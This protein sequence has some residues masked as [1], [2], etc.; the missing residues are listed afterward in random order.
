MDKLT[1]DLH[2]EF[3]E[4]RGFST[5]HLKYMR[6]L[7]ETYA[8][9]AFVQQ[10]VA[11]M[12][13]GHNVI[14]MDKVKNTEEREWYI[15]ATIENGWS[16]N[17]LVHQIESGLFQRQGKAVTN[18]TQTLPP[19][20]S[21]LAQQLLK[22]PYTFDFLT[23]GD[24]VQERDVERG[25]LEQIRRTLLELG[26]GFAFVGSQYH[27][28]VGGQDFYLDLLFYHLRLRCFVVVDLKIGDFKP[29][30]AGK[31]NFYLAVADDKLKHAHLD[32]PSIGLILCKT[33]NRIIAEYTLRDVSRLIG[34]AEYQVGPLP[35]NLQN[36]LPSL[37]SLE[38]A[39]QNASEKAERKTA[40][41]RKIA[42]RRVRRKPSHQTLMLLTIK[43]PTS[44]TRLR[45]SAPP[46]VTA[47]CAEFSRCRIVVPGRGTRL[48]AP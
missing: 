43:R 44:S 36:S 24:E 14:L 6:L 23:L 39:L 35:E 1:A 45:G 20:Q 31:M 21:E 3:P 15:Q 8:D 11:Q 13:W 29:E 5:R 34:V 19:A 30:Y 28:E 37:Q 38:R 33:N 12:P 25:L 32:Q 4:M 48:S 22:D 27:L 42:P 10:A 2:H 16:R 7:A 41:G 40:T 26:A 46:E 9:F 18:F 47:L 17:V